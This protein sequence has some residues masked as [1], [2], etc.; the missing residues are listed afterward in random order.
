MVVVARVAP[1]ARVAARIPGLNHTRYAPS[2]SVV[3]C[4]VVVSASSWFVFRPV[5]EYDYV[6]GEQR[7]RTVTTYHSN[8]GGYSG[9]SGSDGRTPS[10]PLY[11][12]NDG[13]NGTVEI[14]VD[15]TRRGLPTM[16]YKRRYD[17]EL[18]E[19]SLGEEE[20]P[21]CDG[22]FEFGEVCHATNF[23][24]ENVGGMPTPE[25]RVRLVQ[26]LT[27][28]VRPLDDE[29]LLPANEPILPATRRGLPGRLRFLIHYPPTNK[30][31]D[32]E[33]IV[34]TDAQSMLATQLGI[35]VPGIPARNT[36]FQRFYPRVPLTKRVLTAQ[37]P[38]G[39][40]NGVIGL[41]SLAYGETRWGEHSCRL[42]WPFP[43]SR[44]ASSAA[45]S[46]STSSTRR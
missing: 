13:A 29:L 28:W 30:S 11:D 44:P 45:L 34:I 37:F 25:Q 12:G 40:A 22:I 17:M 18:P 3:G 42:T 4:F 21:N 24:F 36:P 46:I 5:Q 16:T 10:T 15:G 38:L 1:V 39:N 23:V 33:P 20:G 2:Y 41:R 9:P 14:I 32:F 43:S 7:S 6:N 8:P 35:E 31:E 27:A 26:A 19:F